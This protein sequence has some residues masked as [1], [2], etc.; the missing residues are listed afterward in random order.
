MNSPK[1][2]IAFRFHV[3][4]YHSYRGDT[5]DEKGF[6][7]D[8]RIIRHIIKTLDNFDRQGINVSGTWDCENYFSL[9]TIIPEYCPDIIEDW[10]RRVAEGRDEFQIMSYNNGIISAHSAKEFEDVIRWSISNKAKSGLKDIFDSFAP[11]VR[12]QEMMFTPIHL[13]LYPHYGITSVSL[14]NSAL[15]FNCFSNFVPP[16]SL[17]QRYNPLTLSYQGIEETMTL[18]PAYN[19]GDL[20]DN[21]SLARWV[22]KIRK[23]QLALKDT[24]DLLLLIDM[25]ADDEFWVSMDYPIVKKFYSSL[26]G[27]EGMI[28]SL[29]GLDY[30][31][32]TTPGRYIKNHVPVG[33]IEIRQDTANGSFDGMAC[34]AEKWSNQ[35]LWT[36]IERSRI[37]ELQT[38][39]MLKK[40]RSK[41]L[42]NEIESFSTKSY[43]QR[44][45]SFSTTHFGLS[46]PI[47][48]VSRINAANSIVK[49]SVDNAYQAFTIVKEEV[50]KKNS[51]QD[52]F[53]ILDYARGINTDIIKYPAAPSKGLTKLTLELSREKLSNFTLKDSKG[54]PV[55]F[56]L[57]F[58]SETSRTRK[59]N[60]YY[61]ES[62]KAE[63][64][65]EYQLDFQGP[66]LKENA[67]QSK[68]LI[69]DDLLENEMLS[70]RFD[71]AYNFAGLKYK[72]NDFIERNMLNSAVTYAK[73]RSEVKEWEPIDCHQRG[74]G[75]LGVKRMK[76][77]LLLKAAGGKKVELKR[78]FKLAAGLPYLYIDVAVKYPITP[79]QKYNEERADRLE[80]AW[81]GNWIEVM[82]CEIIPKIIGTDFKHLRVWKHNYFG[83]VSNYDLNYA[84]FSKNGELDSFNN[85][86]TFSWVAVSDGQ[87]GILI[88]QTADALSSFAFCPMRTRKEEEKTRIHL[89]PF[90]SYYGRQFKYNTA[91]TGL[92]KAAAFMTFNHLDPFAPSYNGKKQSFSLMIAPYE[93]DEPPSEIQNDALAF[94][95]PYLVLSDSEII[96]EPPHRRWQI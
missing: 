47:M 59:A 4:F 75:I 40:N 77:E 9:E 33:S 38:L 82:P 39:R 95:Y 57:V 28:K 60:L 54:D 55:P 25:D 74:N 22:K 31:V 11:M 44:L 56:D 87:R 83:H 96:S 32:Y 46:S 69:G 19:T 15:P 93:G 12:P 13:K 34:W 27:L 78:Q 80:K 26:Q 10:K 61:I 23:Q 53:S 76:T 2:H 71:D 42:R 14:F 41:K 86:V 68:L 70:V 58:G 29:Q 66:R 17:V 30:I 52:F 79:Y 16:L 64:E 37:L 91:S 18:I 85:Q 49:S 81:D 84:D 5:P 90:G 8:I 94:A 35:R 88:A 24:K 48:N 50:Y 89:N 43:E 6:G 63:E 92:G 73:H 62:V 65:K 45:R 51:H 7:K 72:G 21:I 36:G 67:N 1:I 3:N 20:V